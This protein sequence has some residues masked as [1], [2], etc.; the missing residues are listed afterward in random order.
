MADKATTTKASPDFDAEV[1]AAIDQLKDAM[2]ARGDDPGQVD[3]QL[4]GVRIR[5]TNLVGNF[6]DLQR[7]GGMQAPKSGGIAEA[8]EL[9]PDV[10]PDTGETRGK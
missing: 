9:P 3:A 6:A 10:D 2:V 5:E 1:Q 8:F 7:L 4:R